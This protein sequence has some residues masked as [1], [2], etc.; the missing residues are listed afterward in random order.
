MSSSMLLSSGEF[1]RM[2]N[3]SCELL[4]HY[5]RI[6]LLKSKQVT[7]KGYRYYSLKQL[8]L[9]D[10]IR[11]FVDTGMPSREIKE[12]LE[13]RST[14][15]FLDTIETGLDKLRAQRDLLDARIGM[16]E[17][18]RYLTQRMSGFPKGRPKLS[19]WDDL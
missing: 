3:V 19:H 18:M 15:L 6:G 5:D 7:E 11:F 8:Y 13:N 4:I 1:A 10:V 17:K 12:Y 16:M 14:D 9:F 2:C